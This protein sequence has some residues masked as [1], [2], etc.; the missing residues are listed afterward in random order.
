[1]IDLHL[2]TNLSDGTFTPIETVGQVI[3]SG[4]KLFSITDHDSARA[5][6]E[7]VEELK[8]QNSDIKY[9]TGTEMSSNFMGKNL[10][11][12]CYDFDLEN[13]DIKKM[14]AHATQLRKDRALELL[15]HLKDKY[16]IHIPESD[17]K[18]LLKQR[19]IAKPHI[20]GLVIKNGLTDLSMGDFIT[21]YIDEIDNKDLKPK[22]EEVISTVHKAGGFVSFAHPL[23]V[24]REY[25]LCYNGLDKFIKNLKGE[26]LDC[27]EAYHS[28][29]NAERIEQYKT[30]A[31]KHKLLLTA[32]SDFHGSHPQRKIGVVSRCGITVGDELLKQLPLK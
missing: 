17:I 32:G 20:A 14:F 26:K 5:N 16:K 28:I 10:H 30:L 25:G 1:M 8:R 3:A 9:I 4:C 11:L 18:E 29:H 13:K 6:G 23:E 22:A 2:H 12:L 24:Q 7:V 27:I 19:I 21:K 15:F 31:K